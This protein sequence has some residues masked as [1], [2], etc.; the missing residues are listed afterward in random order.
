MRNLPVISFLSEPCKF[1]YPIFHKT[2]RGGTACLLQGL[3]FLVDA[4]LFCKVKNY[5]SILKN[6]HLAQ[7]EK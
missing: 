7:R 2:R 5:D 3:F 4:K 1:V 6:S